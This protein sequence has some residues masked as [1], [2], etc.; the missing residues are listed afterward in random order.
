VRFL[1]WIIVRED[2]MLAK[3]DVLHKIMKTTK[4]ERPTRDVGVKFKGGRSFKYIRKWM[5]WDLLENE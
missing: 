2:E 1:K 3:D 4:T 5:F